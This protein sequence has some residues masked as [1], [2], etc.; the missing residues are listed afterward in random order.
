MVVAVW[1]TPQP[2]RFGNCQAHT[3]LQSYLIISQNFAIHSIK[4]NAVLRLPT[5]DY[6]RLTALNQKTILKVLTWILSIEENFGHNF[7]STAGAAAIL[8]QIESFWLFP[9][10]I[11]RC[12]IAAK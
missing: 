7:H 10:R 4:F 6:S 1:L 3:L 8:P 11:S 2:R 12:F 9:K 5:K